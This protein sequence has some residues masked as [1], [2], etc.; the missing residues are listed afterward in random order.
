MAKIQKRP[1]TF[2]KS[3]KSPANAFD[4]TAIAPS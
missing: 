1:G 2:A 3:S 4:A